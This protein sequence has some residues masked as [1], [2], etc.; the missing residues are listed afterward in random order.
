[1][2][3]WDAGRCASCGGPC[4]PQ[5]RF[6]AKCD[7]DL[8]LQEAGRGRARRGVGVNFWADAK[9]AQVAWA[10]GDPRL[11]ALIAGSRFPGLYALVAE[12]CVLKVGMAGIVYRGRL[13]GTVGERLNHHLRNISRTSHPAWWEFTQALAGRELIV[14]TL[15]VDGSPDERR[16]IERDAVREALDGS[17]LWESMKGNE[18]NERQAFVGK[19]YPRVLVEPGAIRRRLEVE[20]CLR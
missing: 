15:R 1:M 16:A 8:P 3:T 13:R 2:L 20:L 10:P 18:R 6:C 4:Y 19:K 12:R 11:E 17:V 9:Q 14:H 5:W 7:P